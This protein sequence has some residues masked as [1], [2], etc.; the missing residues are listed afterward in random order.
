MC[1]SLRQKKLRVMA[2]DIFKLMNP[3]TGVARRE[4]QAMAE[5]L[6]PANGLRG[7]M[8]RKGKPPVNHLKQ[9]KEELRTVENILRERREQLPPAPKQWK[10]KKFQDVPSKLTR[11]QTA[12]Q[13]TMTPSRSESQKNFIVEN[14]MATITAT[15]RRRA[16]KEQP[17]FRSVY[18]DYGKVPVYLQ[19]RKSELQAQHA[20]K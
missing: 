12:P 3:K 6:Y 18:D 15:P 16:V 11:P 10:L 8:E 1:I 20:Q 19:E 4:G 5:L 9:H 2:R 17:D 14:A 7:E 13:R